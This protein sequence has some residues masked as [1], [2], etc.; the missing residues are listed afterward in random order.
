MTKHDRQLKLENVMK[1]IV[2]KYGAH[3]V[4]TMGEYASVPIGVV[5]S[6][7][8]ALDEALGIGGFPKGRIT[9]IFGSEDSGKTTIALHAIAE[10]LRAGGTAAFLD[11]EQSLDLT[12][13]QNLGIDVDKLIIGKPRNGEEALDVADMLIRSGT[14]DIIVVDSVAALVPRDELEGDLHDSHEG[15]QV[16]LIEKGLRRLMIHLSTHDTI[17]I[18]TN[19]V[20]E[21]I[22]TL[23]FYGNNEITSGG[24]ALRYYSTIRLDV[25]R[26]SSGAIRNDEDAIIGWRTVI[27]VVKNKVAPPYKEAKLKLIF[28]K[29][30]VE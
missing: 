29:G 1:D 14:I 18:F 16:R 28:G 11:V 10:T 3:A 5:S 6:G 15:L 2:N 7:L 24:R 27:T 9:E 13:I 21:K 20:R 8:P 23:S 19:Q 26:I 12:Y 22:P 17:C 25:R 4:Q 30:F